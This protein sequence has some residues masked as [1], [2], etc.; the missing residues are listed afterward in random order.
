MNASRQN[1]FGGVGDGGTNDRGDREESASA[2]VGRSD[3]MLSTQNPDEQQFS[4]DELQALLL[5]NAPN[6]VD[7]ETRAMLL[8]LYAWNGL[9]VLLVNVFCQK[10]QNCI[11]NCKQIYKKTLFMAGYQ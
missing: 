8:E 11:R 6:I 7:G 5:D 1:S 4:M 9:Y 3:M 2:G 10:C